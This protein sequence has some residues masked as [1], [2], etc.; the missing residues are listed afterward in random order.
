ME[1]IK[2][3][4]DKF[5]I[6]GVCLGHEA[7]IEH[8]GGNLKFVEPMHG[9]SS[10]IEHDGKTIF[11]D[12]EEG[13]LAGRYHSLV[14]DKIPECF[15]ISAR[16]EDIVMAIRHKDLPIEAVQFHPESVLSMKRG[17]GFKMISNLVNDGI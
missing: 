8:F 2:K 4:V 16:F 10:E 13:F 7:L 1:I 9:K 5:P 6:F 15:D 14:G 17:N 3:C 12:I 11:K